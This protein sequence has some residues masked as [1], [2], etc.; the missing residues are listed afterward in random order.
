MKLNFNFAIR[1]KTNRN[2]NILEWKHSWEKISVSNLEEWNYTVKV[3]WIEK[4]L[5]I[6]V[7][8]LK[9]QINPIRVISNINDENNILKYLKI[10]EID[11]VPLEGKEFLKH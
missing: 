6:F 9:W 11:E 7:K 5:Y 10:W 8:K 4:N 2:V 3:D 1:L